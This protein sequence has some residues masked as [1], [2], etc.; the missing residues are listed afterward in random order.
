[1]GKKCENINRIIVAN[2]G[3]PVVGSEAACLRG[4]ILTLEGTTIPDTCKTTADVYKYWADLEEGS[5][6]V[7]IN[8][9]DGDGQAIAGA[10]IVLKKGKTIGEGTV[11]TAG[12][13]GKF[14]CLQGGYNFS[15]AK[16]G[17]VTATG[18][19]DITA[20]H[21]KAGVASVDVTLEASPDSNSGQEP[22]PGGN[23]ESV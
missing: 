23:G 1:M 17:Y 11:V 7:S 12:Q 6:K 21:V 19:F 22:G 4:L 13:D 14:P 3:T 9:K 18:T 15:I 16:E 20:S 5:A 8:V 10:T 2:G